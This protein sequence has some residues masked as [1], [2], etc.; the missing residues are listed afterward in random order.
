MKMTAIAKTVENQ[1]YELTGIVQCNANADNFLCVVLAR[2]VNKYVTW[3]YNSQD[4]GLYHGHYEMDERAG[5]ED[6]NQR[7]MGFIG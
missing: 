4:G 1:G 3:I 2:R 6:F 5:R 7:M